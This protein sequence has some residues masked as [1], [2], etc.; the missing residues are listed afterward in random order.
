M[1]ASLK[2]NAYHLL[3]L[4]GTASQ[5]Q[6]LQ[7]ANEIVQRLKIE[8]VPDYDL[9]LPAW[10]NGRTEDSVKDALR[11]LQAP[12]SRLKEYFFWFR[13]FDDTDKQAAGYLT[14][15]EFD[16]AFAVWEA[17]A[18]ESEAGVSRKRNLAL[19]Q[20]VS[21]LH[22]AD[23]VRRTEASLSTWSSLLDSPTFWKAF[24]TCYKT[25]AEMLSDEAIAEFRTEAAGNLSDIYAEIQE[26]LGGDDFV[27]RFQQFF[28]GRGKKIEEN[29]LNPVFQVVESA[30]DQLEQVKLGERIT[31]TAPKPTKSRGLL[32]RYP[33]P[34]EQTY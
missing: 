23:P 28:D 34:V 2:N 17:G 3:G 15:K 7:R 20:T 11:R 8:D 27:Y 10:K 22:G 5:K 25:D 1:T 24:A 16:K 26:V 9:D 6:I 32:R 29:I 21:L 13:I 12:K 18:D 33:G 31:M 30:I 19:A 14:R 4:S